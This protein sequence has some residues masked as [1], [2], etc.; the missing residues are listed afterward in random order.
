MEDDWS[1]KNPKR[2]KSSNDEDE[3]KLTTIQTIVTN[4]QTK[5]RENRN[6]PHSY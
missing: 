6:S 4:K 5:Q 3:T 1:L 2:L